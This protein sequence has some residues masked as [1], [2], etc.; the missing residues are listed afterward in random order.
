M[1]DG[2]RDGVRERE[3]RER[4]GGGRGKREGGRRKR[5]ERERLSEGHV[6]YN[7]LLRQLQ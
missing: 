3:G 2:R 7:C 4:E 5:E 1:S 6:V